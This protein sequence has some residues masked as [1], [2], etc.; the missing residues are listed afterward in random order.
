M[1]NKY[2]IIFDLTQSGYRNWTAAK[3]GIWFII[4][5][6]C[7]LMFRKQLYKFSRPMWSGEKLPLSVHTL[8][9]SVFTL[10]AVLW[11]VVVIVGTFSD[12]QELQNAIK[13][14]NYSI[15]EGVVTDFEPMPYEGHKDE[16]FC[17][18]K[19]CFRYSDYI[20]TNAFNNTSS[21]GG[22]IKSRLY[23][24]VMHVEN[25]IVRLEIKE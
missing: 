3:T 21:H 5:G 8:F 9:Y 7:L 18:E 16:K 1:E 17:I 25:K 2:K 23:V 6:L 14:G 15:I 12:Y 24:R 4:L 13:A 10:F 20:L 11:T 19:T 22:P